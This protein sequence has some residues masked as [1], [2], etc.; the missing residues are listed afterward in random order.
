[1]QCLMAQ[2]EGLQAA[3]FRCF[4]RRASS[5]GSRQGSFRS[6]DHFIASASGWVGFLKPDLIELVAFETRMD[7]QRT[8][9]FAEGGSL[10]C[11]LRLRL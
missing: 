10:D 9:M 5:G 8:V 6:N 7:G 1:M 11:C 4:E 2:V 3:E